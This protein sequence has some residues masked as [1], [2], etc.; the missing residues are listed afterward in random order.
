MFLIYATLAAC[1]AVAA[2][3]QVSARPTPRARPVETT[4]T[5]PADDSKKSHGIHAAPPRA[6]RSEAAIRQALEAT[7]DLDFTKTPFDDLVGAIGE[8]TKIDIVLDKKALADMGMASDLPMTVSLRGI[9]VRAALELILHNLNLTWVVRDEVILIT[10]PEQ[11]ESWMETRVYDVSD[12]VL[13]LSSYPFEGMYIPE[14]HGARAGAGGVMGG[15]AALGSAT[16]DLG[17]VA[18]SGAAGMAGKQGNGTGSGSTGM[19]AVV[20]PV[21]PSGESK[22]PKASHPA[23]RN[24]PPTPATHGGTGARRAVGGGMGGMAGGMGGMGASR[25][26]GGGMGGMAGGMGA[27]GAM[28]GAGGAMADFDSLVDLITSTIN[29]TSWDEVGGPGSIKSFEGSTGLLVFSQTQ[30]THLKTERLLEQ[31]RAARSKTPMVTVRAFWL[32]LDM[33][34]LDDLLASKPGRPGGIDRKALREM[35]AKAKGYVGTINCFSGQTVHIASGHGRSAVVGA[36]P[37]ADG[38]MIGYQPIVSIPQCGAFLQVT[39]QVLPGAKTVVVDLQSSVVRPGGPAE[40][41]HFLRGKPAGEKGDKASANEQAAE[42]SVT[43]DRVN[44]AVEQ[45]GTTLR[46]PVGEPTLVGGLT[47]EPSADQANAAAAP[48]LYLFVEVAAK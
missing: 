8:F 5:K 11:A 29:P 33:K 16:Q 13:P 45:L 43:L 7:A 30:E 3:V 47:H 34:Q 18:M 32:L 44:V 23:P 21:Q 48:Q 15:V 41:V 14:A 26:M 37:V 40:Q 31:I 1:M 46:L 38:S 17:T 10:S 27:G 39:P 4:V 25:G 2:D 36:I 6:L 42:P 20:E 24:E 12:L 35:A 9:S 22:A 28:G 19:F